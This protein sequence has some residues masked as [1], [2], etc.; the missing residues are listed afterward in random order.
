LLFTVGEDGRMAVP[1]SA[2]ARLEEIGLDAVERAGTHDVV[3]YRGQIMPLVRV[4][5]ALNVRGAPPRDPMQVIVYTRDGRSV[6]LVVNEILDVVEQS[7]E[8]AKNGVRGGLQGTAVIQQRVTDLV[9][10]QQLVAAAGHG[11]T[12]GF[13]AVEA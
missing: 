1:L 3:Q 12:A 10:V 6:G 5:E 9:D 11:T 8:T 13:A 2:V 7:V 4:S